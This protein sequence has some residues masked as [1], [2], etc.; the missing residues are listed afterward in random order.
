MKFGNLL[1][2][3]II[4]SALALGSAKFI[5]IILKV[6]PCKLCYYQRYI[7][8]ALITLCSL[9]FIRG[10]HLAKLLI[11][12]ILLLSSVILSFY[13][14]GVELGWFSFESECTTGFAKAN[15]FLE[16]KKMLKNKDIVSCDQSLFEF[17]GI[18]MAGWNFIYSMLLLFITVYITIKSKW[19]KDE[20]TKASSVT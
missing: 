2:F 11:V 15:T 16:Y 10:Y 4:S 12:M 18:S 7:Y 6:P 9:F 14:F 5:E 19:F 1:A 8:V 3:L 20:K 13:H 17:L